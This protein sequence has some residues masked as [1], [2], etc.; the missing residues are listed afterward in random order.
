MASV[1]HVYIFVE[2]FVK[3]KHNDFHGDVND[4]KSLNLC[5]LL[6]NQLFFFFLFQ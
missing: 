4:E 1:R 6:H 5:E 3:I 2:C